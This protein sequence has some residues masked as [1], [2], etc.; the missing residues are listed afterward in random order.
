MSQI[1]VVPLLR[2]TR[3]NVRRL[4]VLAATGVAVL[5]SP[6]FASASENAPPDRPVVGRAADGQL[7]IFRLDDKGRLLH[8]WRRAGNGEWS[9][10]SNLG[11]SLSTG[12][13][14]ANN[15]GG[16]M[17]VFAVD[18]EDHEIKYLRQLTTNSAEWSEWKSLGGKFASPI[19]V[20]QDAVGRLEL[21]AVD[22]ASRAV[23]H[24]C[25]TNNTDGWSEWTD[26][27]GR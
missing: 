20:G 4:A 22:A 12:L 2:K 8:R 25:Q 21:F 3:E 14:V 10:W 5:S 17:S 13:V 18:K 16:L 6:G 7:E 26:L 24:L 23:K 15:A 19:A 1:R 27:G 11:G 9:F